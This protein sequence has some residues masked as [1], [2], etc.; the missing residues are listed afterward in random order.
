MSVP[1]ENPQLSCS[2]LHVPVPG[3]GKEGGRE[4][5]S[6]K[7]TTA[8]LSVDSVRTR[9]G[10]FPKSGTQILPVQCPLWV[11]VHPYVLTP[12]GEEPAVPAAVKAASPPCPP[13]P[14]GSPGPLGLVSWPASSQPTDWACQDLL[15]HCPMGVLGAGMGKWG[16]CCMALIH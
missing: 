12:A 8:L 9:A 7:Q 2:R 13:P 15:G 11:T 16:T 6:H 10:S 1:V 14:G 4:K 3:E 5:N